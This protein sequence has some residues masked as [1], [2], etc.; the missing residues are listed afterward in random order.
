MDIDLFMELHHARYLNLTELGR[1]DFSSRIGFLSLMKKQ[2][3]GL[4][5]G[6]ASIRYRRRIPFLAEFELTTKLICHD[7]R[8]LYFL[9]E[10]YRKNRICASALIK[11][12]VTSKDGL[13]PASQV[14]EAMGKDNWDNEMPEWVSA[15]IQA[16]GQ[17]PWPQ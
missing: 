7:G 17:R 15:W 12:G 6:G 4:V 5:I 3:W 16:E 9:H 2:K 8:W 14:A 1:L 11:G 13:V 10:F